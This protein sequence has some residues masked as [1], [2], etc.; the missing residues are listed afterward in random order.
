VNASH[1]R[2]LKRRLEGAGDDERRE[3]K[4]RK[5]KRKMEEARRIER[6]AGKRE[7]GRWVVE[8]Q[9]LPSLLYRSKKS[10]SKF[11]KIFHAC[12]CGG[13]CR[14]GARSNPFFGTGPGNR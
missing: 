14:R 3:V 1:N 9:N 13:R 2:N 8:K 11:P 7:G 6:R 12:R 4:G 10:S 5:G